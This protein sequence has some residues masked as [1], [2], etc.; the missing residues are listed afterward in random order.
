MLIYML[1]SQN[2]T[3]Q[4]ISD[5]IGIAIAIWSGYVPD[6][7][8]VQAKLATWPHFCHK[9]YPGFMF[10]KKIAHNRNY[11]VH[12]FDFDQCYTMPRA[13]A[14]N[15]HRIVL[16]YVIVFDVSWSGWL[17]SH[18]MA[19]WSCQLDDMIP[20]HNQNDKYTGFF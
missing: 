14:W 5:A 2:I 9:C 4:F 13:W 1:C 12:S 7:L 3:C 10:R 19:I 6:Y 8:P 11:K 15:Y 17:E 18:H 16:S 20:A